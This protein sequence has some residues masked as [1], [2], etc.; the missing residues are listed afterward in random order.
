M[1]QLS[2]FYY[3]GTLTGIPGFRPQRIFRGM[4][5]EPRHGQNQG[6]PLPLDPQEM[7]QHQ[8]PKTITKSLLTKGAAP[9]KTERSTNLRGRP[10]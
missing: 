10:V 4:A 7:L 8:Q 3:R 5:Q 1:F 9:A 6:F 2:G